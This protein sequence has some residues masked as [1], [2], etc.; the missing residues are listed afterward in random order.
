MKVL[1]LVSAPTLTGPA[2]PALGLARGQKALGIDVMLGF[3]TQRT[4]TMA[5][6]VAEAGVP[7]VPEL[8]LSTKAGLG[9]M[10]R[11]RRW[12]QAHAQDFD[13]VHVHTSHDHALAVGINGR[14]ALV[15]SIHHP[16]GCRRRGLQGYIYKRTTGFVLVASA[17][18][19]LLLEAYPGLT[20]S[21]AVVVPGAV[22]PQRF[23]PDAD[24]ASV[25][26]EMGFS[27]GRRVVGMVARIKAGRGHSLIL[28]ALLEARLTA[29]ELALAL[30]GKG[31]GV[32]EVK[33]QVEAMGLSEHVAW[34]GYRDED[35]AEAI[36]A[37]DATV[38][39]NEGNDASCRA[40]LESLSCGVPV[41]GAAHP[42]IA[43]ALA[44]THGRLFEPGDRAG[45]VA[46][47]L[48]AVRWSDSERQGLARHARAQVLE[49]H[50]D[51]VRAQ[52]V[53]QA[54]RDWG[55]S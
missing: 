30:I 28:E 50:T 2:D 41:I 31:E 27:A 49:H 13:V 11:D 10:W 39:L 19:D 1:H 23:S 33:A 20:P 40:V 37:C 32:P 8:V 29:P 48:D 7:G 21:R 44:P 54:Y 52:S 38:L 53:L 18:R 34:L 14:T 15:R 6:K 17:H 26:D 43:D 3:D 45:L 24:G 9:A 22:D 42:A 5:G 25:R 51:Q 16:R 36:R 12:I 55:I 47:L 35:L 46:G 4:G